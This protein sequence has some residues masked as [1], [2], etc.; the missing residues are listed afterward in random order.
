MQQLSKPMYADDDLLRQALFFSESLTALTT[1]DWDLLISQARRAVLLARLET[2]LSERGL[3]ERV[4]EP[5]RMHL[6][7]ARI[8]AENEDRVMRWE[9]NRIQ[10]A[11]AGIDT[12]IVLL[13]GAAYALAGLPVAKGRLASDVDILV[14]KEK[15]QAV[16][17]RLLQ[18]GWHHV[19]L[20]QYDQSFYR[21]W[22]HELPPL[23]HRDRK[24]IVDIHHTILPPTGRLHPDPR[25]LLK[26]A[27]PVE[28]T[29]FSVLAP[30]DM[31][32]HSAAHAFQDGDFQRVLRDLVDLDALLRHFGARQAFWDDLLSRAE[33]LELTR[34][35]FYALRYTHSV[36]NTPVPAFVSE[37]CR[38]RRP[39]WPALTIMDKLVD[40]ALTA[41]GPTGKSRRTRFSLWLLYIRSHWLRM[42][43]WLLAR[44]LL[45]Q[46]FQRWCS[47]NK[48]SAR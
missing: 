48:A 12:P 37:Q 34:P 45:R 43:P 9:I 32:L 46:S 14:L 26:A 33:E 24:T 28:G 40:H 41:S 11:L 22:S 8:V 47:A 31:A 35:L 27:V 3:L 29:K 44:H 13:K 7:S 42:P 20:E 38:K 5:V 1:T 2:L 19:K 25:K 39:V 10:R 30:A 4:P 16:E 21:T 17:E 18:H 6:E 23:Q 36:L 15:L